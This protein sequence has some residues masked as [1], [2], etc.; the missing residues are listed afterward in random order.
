MTFLLRSF[1]VF[2]FLKGIYLFILKQEQQCE[3]ERE[4]KKERER[5]FHPLIYSPTSQ[6]AETDRAG[7]EG[8]KELRVSFGFHKE[9]HTQA[10][11]PSS[12]AFLG[13]LTGC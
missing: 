5:I 7:T 11:D 10:I 8:C 9:V 1:T 2:A 4:K 6:M 13:P 12:I 3:K